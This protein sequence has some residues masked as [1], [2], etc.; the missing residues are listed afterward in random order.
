MKKLDKKLIAI[1]IIV[2]VLMSTLLV[3]Y[4]LNLK[5]Q[6][7]VV[8]LN[9]NIELNGNNKNIKY[10]IDSINIDVSNSICTINGWA[11]IKGTNSYNIIPTMILRDE[12]GKLYKL[13]TRIVVRKDITKLFNGKSTDLNTH[14]TCETVSKLGMTQNKN[15]YDN[16]GIISKF[17]IND[18]KKDTNYKI[19]IQLNNNN[20][21]YFIWT[22]N[23]LKL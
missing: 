1:I 8:K 16:S 15:V 20:K 5:K 13:E 18:L 21:L 22:S 3:G 23:E 2:V 12:K 7:K 14:L 4:D 10:K 9:K 19:G 17:Q 11:I 6:L